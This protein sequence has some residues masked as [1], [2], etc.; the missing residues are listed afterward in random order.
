[1]N[2][3]FTEN[4][5]DSLR[6]SLKVKNIL[7]SSKTP[8]QN[9]MI[10][11]TEQY[12]KALILDNIIQTTEYDEFFYHEMITHVPLFTHPDP[13]KILIIG[14]GD[15]GAVREIL[16]HDT[17]EK[18]TLVDIDEEVIKTSKL[19][20]PTIGCCLND[21]KVEV[22]CTDGIEFIKGKKKYY[23]IIIVDSTDPVGPA[24]GL[25]NKEFYNNTYDALKDDGILTV[26]SESPIINTNVTV[27]IYKT[28]KNI[29]PVTYLYTGIVPTYQ[30]GLWCFTLGSKHYDPLQTT[31]NNI[32]FIT[33]YFT[34]EIFKACFSL[35]SFIKNMLEGD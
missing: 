17:V 5:S 9:L 32:G 4:Q 21:P 8:Y 22:I 12:G 30:G 24:I 2:I 1:M 16:K 19:F 14:G 33:K 31:V 34:P 3:W 27:D 15:G 29:Y 28:I 6:L 25:F 23:D 35:P 18:V 20:L 13:K 11:E 7:Y 10:V 26:Q